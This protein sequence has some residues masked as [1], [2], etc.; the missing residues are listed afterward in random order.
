MSAEAAAPVGYVNCRLDYDEI[1]SLWRTPFCVS[2]DY[3]VGSIDEGMKLIEMVRRAEQR[4][5]VGKEERSV[6]KGFVEMKLGVYQT[7]RTLAAWIAMCEETL[8]FLRKP[9]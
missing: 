8:T 3:E 7:K 2:L 1:V 5:I 6:L 9:V 4:A